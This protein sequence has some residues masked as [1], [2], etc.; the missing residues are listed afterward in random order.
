MS[1]KSIKDL[2][3]PRRLF[4]LLAAFVCLWLLILNCL[5]PR[6]ADDFAFAYR[7]DNGERILS[8]VDLFQSLW[9]HYFQWTGRV[10]VKIFSQLFNTLPKAVFN[11]AN[12]AMYLLQ[13][14]VLY[15]L[16]AGKEHRRWDVLLFLFIQIALWE[17]NPVFGQNTLWVCGST[18]YMWGTVFCLL[19][20]LPFRAQLRNPGPVTP[21]YTIALT[22]AGL[23]VG[24]M[25]ESTSAGVLVFLVLYFLWTLVQGRRPRLWMVCSFFSTL[26]GFGLLILSPGN[27][28]RSS[29]E[30]AD[31]RPLATQLAVHFLEAMNM[32]KDYAL[33]LLIATVVLFVIACQQKHDADALAWPVLLFLSGM[34]ANFA[35]IASPVYYERSSHGA[36]TLLTAAGA[37]C[38]A[39]VLRDD[40]LRGALRAAAAG[41]CV[42]VAIHM[43]E[44][45]Y[46]IASYYVMY[47]TREQLIMQADGDEYVTYGIEPYTPYC[48]AYDLPD[49]RENGEDSIA[50]G[51]AKWYGLQSLTADEVR[52]YPF[53]GHTN[54]AYEAGL[55]L[56]GADAEE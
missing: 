38:L 20:L 37:A 9:F 49:I 39:L 15:R 46:D 8:P 11:L 21:A 27:T 26:L 28:V 33:F 5:T 43:A 24:W 53:P 51:R 45:G 18:C 32:L 4:I 12:T 44:A 3:T 52:T 7:F 30:V 56:T 14:L 19:F 17:V 13:G 6:I 55:A 47:T 36:L 34:G 16:A 31:P 42:V 48:A 1:F 22:A 35:F 54:A 29:Q 23:F 10:I 50:L 41:L 25:N 2:L 40:R